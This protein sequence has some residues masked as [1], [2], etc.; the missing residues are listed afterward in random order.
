MNIKYLLPSVLLLINIL[1]L[2]ACQTNQ[3]TDVPP[4]VS[5]ENQYFNESPVQ[6]SGEFL[7]FFEQYGGVDSLGHPLT[8]EIIV[9]GWRVQYFEKGRLE[10]HPENTPAYRVT[11]GWLGELLHR[12]QPP[13][14][15]IA[16]PRTDVSD[17]IYFSKTG[18]TLSGDFLNYFE[19]NGGSVRFGLPISEPFILEGQLAQDFQ[20]ARFFWKPTEDQ[21]ITL[22]SIGQTHLETLTF[23]NEKK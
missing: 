12:R 11:V 22:E 4:I 14:P 18:H 3:S 19:T 6:I 9:D 21:P 15:A 1:S 20:S 8:E 13:I 2:F 10:Y 16:I 17:I 7:Y 5:E 23:P